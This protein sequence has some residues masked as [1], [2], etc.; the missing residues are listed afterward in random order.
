MNSSDLETPEELAEHLRNHPELVLDILAYLAGDDDDFKLCELIAQGPSGSERV[1]HAPC[2][3]RTLAD[4]I[5]HHFTLA[6]PHKQS[7]AAAVIAGAE[8]R[9]YD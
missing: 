5:D 1:G 3:L 7:K 4:L 6:E 2:W 9:L 8:V